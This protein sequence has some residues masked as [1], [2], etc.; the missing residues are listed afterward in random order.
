[1]GWGLTN[2]SFVGPLQPESIVF[3]AV[4][5]VITGRLVCSAANPESMRNCSRLAFVTRRILPVSPAA[6]GCL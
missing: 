3:F 5:G 4:L 2:E 6:Q 1:L